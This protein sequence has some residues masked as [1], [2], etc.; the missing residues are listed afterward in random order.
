MLYLIPIIPLIFLI[1]AVIL[2]RWRT[3]IVLIFIWL[4]AEDVIRRLIPGQ[5]GQI[6]LIKDALIF[7]TYFSFIAAIAINPVRNCISNG[8]KGKKIWKPPFIVFLFLFIAFSLINVFNPQIPNL[9]FGIIGLRSYL[10][11]IPLAFLGYYMFSSKEKL[12]KFCRILVYIAIPLF[13]L[14][15]FQYVFYDVDNVLIRPFATSHYYHSFSLVESGKIPLLSSVFGSVHRY[16]RFSMLLFFLGIGLLTIKRNKPRTFNTIESS[17]LA[18][19]PV[20]VRGKLLIVST[21]CAFLGITLS[22]SR[23]AFALTIIGIV[24]FFL[25][26]KYIK[27]NKILH[28]WRNSRIKIFT[29]ILILLLTL[30]II[31][32][33]RDIGLFNISA[34]YYA[35]QERI[36]WMFDE[37]IRAF[38]EAKFFGIGTGTM[39]QGL[40]YVP[41]GAEWI[42]YQTQEVRQGFWFETGI[43]K[44]LFEL[45]IIGL[46]FYYLFWGYLFYKMKEVIKRLKDSLLRSVGVA[47]FIFS[48]LILVW[49]SFLHHQTFGDATTLVVFWFFIG[50]LFSLKGSK[51]E[52]VNSKQEISLSS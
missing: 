9:L 45:G 34:F 46:I 10:W 4:L 16:A 11:Y 14:A 36:P 19:K 5:P 43:G 7:L 22:G 49:F 18:E 41:G 15:A 24:L 21:I 50:V 23:S 35:F 6:M 28:L 42:K 12:L 17:R 13:I 30:P 44:I 47:I 51:Q 26:A 8:V 20:K 25:F 1:T 39:S 52:L 40:E 37:F 48:F 29:A 33:A 31:F 38:S 2:R 3:G 32:F 27:N